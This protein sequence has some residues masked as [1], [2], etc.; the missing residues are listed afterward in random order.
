MYIHTYM[1]LYKKR[2][3]HSQNKNLNSCACVEI[4]FIRQLHQQQQQH[5]KT[6]QCH[7]N[8]WLKED[9]TTHTF[10]TTWIKVKK[11]NR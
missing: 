9:N 10:T 3:S 11:E 7:W 8:L 1:Y 2:H 4:N 5:K 6:L